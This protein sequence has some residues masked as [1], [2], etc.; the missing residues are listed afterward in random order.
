[1]FFFILQEFSQNNSFLFPNQE[2]NMD[3]Y[4]QCHYCKKNLTNPLELVCRHSYCSECITKEIQND[5][6]NCPVCATEHTAPASSLSSAKQDTLVPY[7]I[8]LN[9]FVS[10]QS[11]IPY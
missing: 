8:G 4:I 1:M 2:L 9:R 11:I 5:K 6:V 3:S 7:L 10:F